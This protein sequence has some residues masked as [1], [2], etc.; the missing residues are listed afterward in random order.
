M[1]LAAQLVCHENFMLFDVTADVIQCR[2]EP[3]KLD[4]NGILSHEFRG[5]AKVLRAQHK[6]RTDDNAW[7]NR[8]SAANLH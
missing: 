5:N 8:Y 6:G 1:S 2:T 7:R 3:K 4:L